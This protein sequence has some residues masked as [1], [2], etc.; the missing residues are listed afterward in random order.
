VRTKKKSGMQ[1][2]KERSSREEVLAKEPRLVARKTV[3]STAGRENRTWRRRNSRSSQGRRS[4]QRRRRG[5]SER[6]R[7]LQMKRGEEKLEGRRAF[8]R[9]SVGLVGLVLLVGGGVLVVCWCGKVV[10]W[11]EGSLWKKPAGRGGLDVAVRDQPDLGK[12]K[13]FFKITSKISHTGKP[14]H[15]F[16][17]SVNGCQVPKVAKTETSPRERVML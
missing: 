9:K 6:Q 8:G 10:L 11:V 16:E 12:K 5:C 15:L 13:E 2:K 1:G 4:G 7:E 17:P 14:R 3:Y